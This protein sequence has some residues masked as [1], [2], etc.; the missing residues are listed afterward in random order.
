MFWKDSPGLKKLPVSAKI[1]ITA[2]LILAGIGYLLG[3][4]NIYLT[5]NLKDGNPG[6]S[7][8]DISKSFYGDREITALEKS[9]DSSMKEY[10]ASYLLVR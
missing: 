4:A 3:F 7:L 6:F 1:G 8:D 9:I 10:F 2:M 5:Y